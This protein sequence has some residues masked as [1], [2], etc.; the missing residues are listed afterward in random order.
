[1]FVPRSAVLSAAKTPKKFI[2]EEKVWPTPLLRPCPRLHASAPPPPGG[3]PARRSVEAFDFRAFPRVHLSR[4]FTQ[5]GR[6][7]NVVVEELPLGQKS[8]AYQVIFVM[9]LVC[10]PPF[11]FHF[12]FF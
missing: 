5:E 4:A 11:H 8:Q 2:P 9:F 10:K 6:R 3:W 7:P 12:I 1:M